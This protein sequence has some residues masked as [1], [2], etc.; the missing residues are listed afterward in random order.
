LRHKRDFRETN[1]SIPSTS[2][3]RNYHPELVS[4][5]TRRERPTTTN[6]IDEYTNS[7]ESQ[8]AT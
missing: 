8:H 4:R 2:T 5:T 7:G 3:S 6:N 1:A